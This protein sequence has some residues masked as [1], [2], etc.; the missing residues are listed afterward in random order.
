MTRR[1]FVRCSNI[2]FLIMKPITIYFI[3]LKRVL[4][5]RRFEGKI[6][7]TFANEKWKLCILLS[8]YKGLGHKSWQLFFSSR[9]V[10]GSQTYMCLVEVLQAWYV[11]RATDGS[12]IAGCSAGRAVKYV[13]WWVSC[14]MELTRVE[15]QA[16]IKIA[17]HWGRSVMECHS[18][19][20]EAIGNSSNNE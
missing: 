12:V 20:I 15:E 7:T 5:I 11:C 2:A 17:F 19:L 8:S 14:K 16:S 18:E 3:F 9:Y 6:T 4:G 1:L 13:N 10:N